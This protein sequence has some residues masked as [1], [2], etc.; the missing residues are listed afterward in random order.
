MILV[1]V[2]LAIMAS[3]QSLYAPF[4]EQLTSITSYNIA[5]YGAMSALER[6]VLVTRYHEPGFSGSGG[7]MGITSYGPA[8]DQRVSNFGRI[9]TAP[10]GM[11]WS[12]SSAV[13]RIPLTGAGDVP[14]DLQAPDSANYNALSYDR[15]SV[16]TL[17]QDATTNTGQY[18]V[19]VSGANTV[20]FSGD[21]LT[22]SL[23]LPSMLTGK[24]QN[25]GKLCDTCDR[26]GDQTRNHPVVN[27]SYA[28]TVNG[29]AFAISPTIS[30]N[31]AV[32]PSI[33]NDSDDN[34]I[35]E[36]AVNHSPQVIR[37]P[38]KTPTIDGNTA[39]GITGHNIITSD[40]TLAGE[41]FQDLFAEATGQKLRLNLVKLLQT[42]QGNIYP[43]LEY[44]LTPSAGT[45]ADTAYTVTATSRVGDYN[46]RIIV[47][48][49]TVRESGVGSFTILF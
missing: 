43:F 1:V 40:A 14:V 18:Y 17:S 7:R 27:R 49:P 10:G 41:T 2:G 34:I 31:Y 15:A 37:G 8:S 22:L 26:N 47:R 42:E 28:G 46:V 44:S 29:N 12:I 9:S 38:D 25:G 13:S 45:I 19:D 48:K 20:D 39:A 23:R 24:F 16:F 35:R 33:P 21:S 36:T 6:G 3:M 5:Y 32:T 11:G 4:V 30:V